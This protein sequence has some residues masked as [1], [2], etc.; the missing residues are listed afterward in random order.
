MTKRNKF[1]QSEMEAFDQR[2]DKIFVCV[3]VYL[4]DVY[5]LL[6]SEVF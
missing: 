6:V 5:F 2:S 4:L 1:T 3:Y